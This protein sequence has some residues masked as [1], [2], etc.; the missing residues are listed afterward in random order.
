MFPLVALQGGMVAHACNHK[1][2]E[3]DAG[4]LPQVWGQYGLHSAFLASMGYTVKPFLKKKKS[5]IKI[6]KLTN[7]HYPCLSKGSNSVYKRYRRWKP[8]AGFC[9]DCRLVMRS[10]MLPYTVVCSEDGRF[11]VF[12][13]SVCGVS[14]WAE[15]KRAQVPVPCRELLAWYLIWRGSGVHG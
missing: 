2:W 4:G 13:L 1:T 8:P 11:A 15:D 12:R 14:T 7:T 10:V 9:S 6:Q 5:Q 3:T